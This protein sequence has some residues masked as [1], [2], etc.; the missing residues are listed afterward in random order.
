MTSRRSRSGRRLVV[1]A[2][3]A[4]LAA[5]AGGAG[6]HDGEHSS[7]PPLTAECLASTPISSGN[8]EYVTG[9]C[10]ATGGHVVVE[11][12]RLYVG[13]YGA[14]MRFF[15]ISNPATP[16]FIGQYVPGT[17]RA[18]AVPDAAVFDGR[19]IA[20]L[21]GTNRTHRSIPVGA[22]R[23]DKTEFLDVS[24]PAHP[25]LLATLGPSLADGEA[26]NGDIVDARRLWLPSGGTGVHGLRIYDLRPLLG[27]PPAPPEKIFT[28]DPAALWAGSPYRQGKPV[29]APFTHTHDITVY[30]GY[31]VAGLGKRDI[32]LL[33]EGGNYAG[34]GNTGSLFVIDITNPSEPVVLLRWLHDGGPEHHP[35][36]YHHE[37]QFLD[38]D[39][40]VVLVTDEDLHSGCEAGGVTAL[41]LSDDLTSATELSEWFLGF[42]TLAPVCSVHVFSSH[43]NL[44]F[45]GAYNAGLQVVDYS[46][47]TLPKRVGH[48]IAPGATSWGAQYHQGYVYVGDMTRGLDTFKWVGPR[49]DLTL[50]RDDI[51]LS[52]EKVVGGDRVTITATIRN[53]GGVDASDVVVRFEVDGSP[54]GADHTVGR[55]AA[56]GSR[57]ASAVWNTKH[58]K[59]EHAITVT[60]DPGNRIDEASEANNSA[61]RTV[62]VRGNKVENGSFESSSSG[63]SPDGW[64]SSGE[65]GYASGGSDGERSVA[66]SALGSWA[67]APIQVDPGMSYGVSVDASGADGTLLVHQ[68]SASGTI[69]ATSTQALTS[70]FGAFQTVGSLLT[71]VPGAT[72]VRIVLA[73]PLAGTATFD[74]VRLWAE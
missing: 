51:A 72:A 66:A 49:P 32:V 25:V 29:G 26:H 17:P 47:P 45:F 37:A 19:H 8:V 2:A 41:R 7:L 48:Y 67:S 52:K 35:I 42:G 21:N 36:R 16:V 14:G 38:G 4:T 24:D 53:T 70:T 43:G 3:L 6:A 28:A 10:G 64:S 23:T 5:T 9:D 63:A 18:D 22:A 13:A 39:P 31:D 40:R 50:G 20:V 1:A 55:I 59:G 15:D 57:T 27:T 30:L 58:L 62:L 60:V 65:T 74:D 34:N 46:D 73:A 71:A 44:V 56:G 69:L 68:L 11:G 33:A 12:N 54:L 61:S